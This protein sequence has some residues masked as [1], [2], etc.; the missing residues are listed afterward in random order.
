MDNAYR[1]TIATCLKNLNST[2]AGLNQ[3]QIDDRLQKY[4]EN[5]LPETKPQPLWVIYLRQFISP[6]IY[7]LVFASFVTIY[8]EEYSGAIFIFLVLLVNAT[9]G[10]FQEYSA[11]QAASSLKKMTTSFAHV[12]RASVIKKIDASQL[13]VGDIILL[14]SGNKVPADIRLISSS[15]LKVDESLLTGESRDVSKQADITLKHEAVTGDQINMVFAGT[16]VSSGRATGLVVRTGL[17]SKLGKIAERLD[18]KSHAKSP[19]IIRMEKFTLQVSALVGILTIIIASILYS[20]NH[21]LE[22]IFLVAVGLAVAAIPEGLPVT[23]TI[24]LAI[25]MRRMARRNVIVR[26]LVAVESLGSC[27]LIASDKTGTLTRNE[28]AVE[29]VLL[30]SGEEFT[31]NQNEATNAN[32]IIKIATKDNDPSD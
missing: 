27:T 8:L 20:Q 21:E 18:E 25:G 13:V 3:T 2:E 29:Y 17:D 32:A 31:I 28:L 5:R 4:G 23:L 15:A 19:L 24:T 26:K 6:L 9:I 30:P 10:A 1:E 7:I 12:R 22:Y 11:N 16:M 14:E